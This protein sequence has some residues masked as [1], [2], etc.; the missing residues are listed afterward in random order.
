MGR[1]ICAAGCIGQAQKHRRE[2][3][4]QHLAAPGK[5]RRTRWVKS[6]ARLARF[7]AKACPALD[8]GWTPVRVKKTR[9][10]KNLEPRFDSIETE[11]ALRVQICTFLEPGVA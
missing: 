10:I 2:S 6:A 7:Q 4:R 1:Q 5:R 11:K 3:H 8:A 9:Q